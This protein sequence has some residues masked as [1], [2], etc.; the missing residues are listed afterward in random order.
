MT[1]LVRYWLAV[2]THSQRFFAPMLLFLVGVV[3]LTTG[4][5]GPLSD[6]YG[7]CA[8]VLFVSALWLTVVTLAAES[9]EQSTVTAVNAGST[10]RPLVALGGAL[11][12]CCVGLLV[13]GL[14]LP[15]VTGHHPLSGA[16]ILAGGLSQLSGALVGIAVGL[17]CSRLVVPRTS[18]SVV[19]AIVLAT[20]VFRVRW[21]TPL[22][23]VLHLN[24]RHQP[25][26]HLVLPVLGLT[27]LSA[28]LA[29]A[30]LGVAHTTASR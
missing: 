11:I 26:T 27:L 5:S 29:G 8:G 23:E 25:P 13:L 10:W 14:L 3:T 12:G 24:A 4:Q 18:L 16:A 2:M 21:A 9:R 15:I 20:V 6:P 30:A 17:L 7:T 1:G 22:Y 28:L 19:V